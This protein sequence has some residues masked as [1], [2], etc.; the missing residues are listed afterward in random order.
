GTLLFVGNVGNVTFI[1]PQGDQ[2]PVNNFTITDTA[3]T[4]T[5]DP[6]FGGFTVQL[7]RTVTREVV[8]RGASE[9][10]FEVSG[11][12]RPGRLTAWQGAVTTVSASKNA[13]LPL[14]NT[15]LSSG[16]GMRLTLSGINTANLT[17]VAT[18]GK[19]PRIVDASAFTGATN[20]VADGT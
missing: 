2:F 16:D 13:G 19:P 17:A 15:S 10:S 3:M 7:S 18:Q 6:S 4:Y 12:T 20:L 11:W 14:P 5:G 9:N 1:G 8:G